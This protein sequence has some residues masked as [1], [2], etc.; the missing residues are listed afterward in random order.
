M[1]FFLYIY[2]DLITQTTY[3]FREKKK[4][5]HHTGG[6]V[7]R[8]YASTNFAIS[9]EIGRSRER[10]VNKKSIYL[11]IALLGY[12]RDLN[13]NISKMERCTNGTVSRKK[14][15]NIILSR[16]KTPIII[17]YKKILQQNING[18]NSAMFGW[19]PEIS[20]FI[21]NLVRGL[22]SDLLN[23]TSSSPNPPRVPSQPA[24]SSYSLFFFYSLQSARVGH[25]FRFGTP[26]LESWVRVHLIE[27]N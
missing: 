1:I 7:C 27:L 17:L 11:P 15:I 16:K 3:L 4:T 9:N 19:D 25:L 2:I 5:I 12:K 21:F 23:T 26:K 14:H 6:N 24:S 8:Y 22:V 20:K 18:K 13:G 10:E